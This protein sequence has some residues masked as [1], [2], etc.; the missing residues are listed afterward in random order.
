MLLGRCI[1]SSAYHSALAS[2]PK[3]CSQR[4][5]ALVSSP[6]H[7]QPQAPERVAAPTGEVCRA[8]I[9]PDVGDHL[10]ELL[11]FGHAPLRQPSI[12]A[13]VNGQLQSC[14]CWEELSALLEQHRDVLDFVNVSTAWTRLATLYDGAGAA[15]PLTV[16]LR[17]RPPVHEPA[18]QLFLARLIDTTAAQ[19]HAFGVRALANVVWAMSNTDWQLRR[20]H[21]PAVEALARQWSGAMWDRLH[22]LRPSDIAN[23]STAIGHLDQHWHSEFTVRFYRAVLHRDEL[24]DNI[25]AA[26][27]NNV[28]YGLSRAR[29]RGLVRVGP[30]TRRRLEQCVVGMLV[31][32]SGAEAEAAAA[33]AAAE[34]EAEAATAGSSLMAG[35]PAA[36]TVAG[37][38]A[39]GLPTETRLA[40]SA[41]VAATAAE[42]AGATV[43][44]AG[45]STAASAVTGASSSPPPPS[46]SGAAAAAGAR[47]PLLQPWRAAQLLINCHKLGLRLGASSYGML[48]PFVKQVYEQAQPNPLDRWAFRYLFSF[49]EA[50]R[51]V[52]P[53]LRPDLQPL[54]RYVERRAAE[55]TPAN[56]A[57]LSHAFRE[58]RC[59]PGEAF[60]G[61][62]FSS[63]QS[64]AGPGEAGGLA[65]GAGM[66]PLAPG[67]SHEPQQ[68]QQGQQSVQEEPQ[69]ERQQQQQLQRQQ[70]QRQQQRQQQLRQRQ[71]LDQQQELFGPQEEQQRQQHPAQQGAAVSWP[72]AGG[73]RSVL[74][75][76]DAQQQPTTQ[77]QVCVQG[78]GQGQA[79]GQEQ[80][81]TQAL[82]PLLQHRESGGPQVLQ[83]LQALEAVE[84][85][86]Q[87]SGQASQLNAREYALAQQPLQ[88]RYQQQHQQQ[89]HRQQQLH[90]IPAQPYPNALAA[91]QPHMAPQGPALAYAAAPQ[92]QQ[93][94]PQAQLPYAAPLQ[95][96]QPQRAPLPHPAP[97]EQ[98]QEL[99]RPPP[100]GTCDNHP[101]GGDGGGGGGA[102]PGPDDDS[103]PFTLHYIC[104]QAARAGILPPRAFLRRYLQ[105]VPAWLRWHASDTQLAQAV[106]TLQLLRWVP[107][108]EVRESLSVALEARADQSPLPLRKLARWLVQ[109]R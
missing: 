84:Q 91:H 27:L 90:H 43:A 99:S 46:C 58:M 3:A 36:V 80:G 67:G 59:P 68:G 2:R 38:A 16:A 9:G 39:M 21:Q 4:C 18:F 17:P 5:C 62:L 101:G 33:A 81:Q 11:G 92:Q 28:L 79:Q 107:R 7:Q 47:D 53:A 1:G 32:A 50:H 6:G 98:Q 64:A 93:P 24:L 95:Q 63:Y 69:Q 83:E 106:E 75:R 102:H 51:R 74:V 97:Q 44:A 29:R 26:T 30:A 70:Q 100:Y 71:L 10:S 55:T 54:L 45:A 105:R 89:L 19:L 104:W 14:T 72:V 40:S 77:A 20:H 34:A 57:L 61:Q 103:D 56:L 42:L 23:I 31:R 60:W 15:S 35:G 8:D 65:A 41:E 48:M 86:A 94:Q 49:V 108:R 88:Q 25:D 12:Q 37:A 52:K 96:Q 87:A 76:P 13:R 82:P 85:Q 22:E 66:Q 109:Q 73:Q 78:Q